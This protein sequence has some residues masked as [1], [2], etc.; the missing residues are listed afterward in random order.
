MRINFENRK[1]A[2]QVVDEYED[3]VKNIH[4][5]AM[6]ELKGFETTLETLQNDPDLPNR[7]FLIAYCKKGLDGVQRNTDMEFNQARMIK[8]QAE[9]VLQRKRKLKL[10][11]DF[12]WAGM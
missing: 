10:V 4:A 9:L 12:T 7:E 3:V 8:E 11:S 1:A 5:K 2:Q 6:E